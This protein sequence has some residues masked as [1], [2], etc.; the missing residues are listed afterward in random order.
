M[1]LYL[2]VK[3]N[4]AGWDPKWDEWLPSD[5]KKVHTQRLDMHIIHAIYAYKTYTYTCF[6]YVCKAYICT[7]H[8]NLPR[9]M[10]WNDHQIKGSSF[11]IFFP[12]WLASSLFENL[13]QNPLYATL[14]LH[15]LVYMYKY[16]HT[17]S[18]TTG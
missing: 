16:T 18:N 11:L 7:V 8:E 1:Y 12:Q 5:S 2:Q 9:S 10:R 14:L 15:M 3:V 4:F 17:R 13:F 6:V